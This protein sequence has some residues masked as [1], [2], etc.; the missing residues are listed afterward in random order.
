MDTN[1]KSDFRARSQA[2]KTSFCTQDR[3]NLAVG[4]GM[5]SPFLPWFQKVHG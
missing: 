1:M 5:G 4:C 3:F 2:N